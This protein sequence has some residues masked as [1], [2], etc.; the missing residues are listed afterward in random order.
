MKGLVIWIS[1]GVAAIAG[2]FAYRYYRSRREG[3]KVLG[4]LAPYS[5]LYYRC[6]SE[7]EKTDPGKQLG[8]NRGNMMCQEYCDA[9]I[10]DISRRGGPSYYKDAPISKDSP[11]LKWRDSIAESY[12]VCGDGTQNE[13]CRTRYTTAYEIETKCQ[14]DCQYSTYPTG[15]C[16][17]L[18]A[19]SM[20]GNYSLG[21]SWK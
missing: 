11:N 8:R 20:L 1:V 9:S 19:K 2:Y 13:E 5:D 4:A 15:K 6:T 16:M 21:W 17:D 3:F 10:T 12:E 18:C 7:C 14:Q